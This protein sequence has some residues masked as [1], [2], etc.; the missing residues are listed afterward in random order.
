MLNQFGDAPLDF[1]CEQSEE[2]SVQTHMPLCITFKINMHACAS[3]VGHI[4]I[5]LWVSGLSG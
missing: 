3:Q 2:Q 1:S 5:A 4:Q